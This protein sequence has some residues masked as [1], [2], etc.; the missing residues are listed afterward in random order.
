MK[1]HAG[2][3]GAHAQARREWMRAMALALL[4]SGAGACAAEP[5]VTITPQGQ[6]A[7]LRQVM[8]HFSEPMQH[9]PER[10]GDGPIVLRCE[11][12]PAR[13][14]HGN[15]HWIDERTAV[16]DLK[17]PLPPRS[18]CT[19]TL[20]ANLRTT[21]GAALPAVPDVPVN[22][23]GPTMQAI[24]PAPGDATL[25]VPRQSFAMLLNGDADLARF[26]AGVHCDVTAN[27][28]GA[29]EHLGVRPLAPAE[30]AMLAKAL[31]FERHLNRV[32]TFACAQPLPPGAQLRLSWM[33][34]RVGA[35]APMQ[36]HVDYGV[37]P[38]LSVSFEP[39]C[40]RIEERLQRPSGLECDVAARRVDADAAV[41]V[42][43]SHSIPQSQAMRVRL[44]SPRGDRVPEPVELYGGDVHLPERPIR[45]IRFE[46]PF[47]A[48]DRLEAVV[49]ADLVDR[50]GKTRIDGDRPLPPITVASRSGS[51]D[52]AVDFETGLFAVVGRDGP[53]TVHAGLAQGLSVTGVRTLR[54]PS[55]VRLV[56]GFDDTALMGWLE[57]S[58]R[59]QGA[60]F[61][62]RFEA[63]RELGSAA[64]VGRVPALLADPKGRTDGDLLYTSSL[65]LLNSDSASKPAQLD[66]TGPR[67]GIA[68]QE[69]GLQV[70][71]LA[72]E[73]PP[74]DIVTGTAYER[75]TVL[76]TDLAVHLLNGRDD[77]VVWVTA[78]STGKPVAQATVQLSDCAGHRLAAGLTDAQGLFRFWA[79]QAV[80]VCTFAGH[81]TSDRFASARAPAAAGLQDVAFVWSS[82]EGGLNPDAW[83]MP[84]A[85]GIAF[86]GS[87]GRD[88][89]AT[90]RTFMPRSLLLAGQTLSMKHWLRQHDD[91]GRALPPR[92]RWPQQVV[93]VDPSGERVALPLAWTDR[94]DTQWS[95]QVPAAARRGRWDVEMTWGDRSE[96]V[97]EF[98]VRDFRVPEAEVTLRPVLAPWRNSRPAT[99][100]VEARYFNGGP[101]VGLAVDLESTLK[102]ATPQSGPAHG[103]QAPEGF[104]ELDFDAGAFPRL[105][106]DEWQAQQNF[107]DE[108]YDD[109][110]D[111]DD[112]RSDPAAIPGRAQNAVVDAQ[113][114]ARF[115]VATRADPN[116]SQVDAVLRF[117]DPDGEVRRVRATGLAW[118]SARRIGLSLRRLQGDDEHA[119]LDVGV[120]D[121][122]GR[123]LAGATVALSLA[124]QQSRADQASLAN[125]IDVV[126]WHRAWKPVALPVTCALVTDGAGKASC[127]LDIARNAELALDASVVDET[128]AWART[129]GVVS[130]AYE[131]FQSGSRRDRASRPRHVQQPAHLDP[132][133]VRAPAGVHAVGEHLG[134]TIPG[135]YDKAPALLTVERDGILE[136]RVVTLDGDDP[137]VDWTVGRHWM[138]G[139][140][141]GVTVVQV[142]AGDQGQGRVGDQFAPVLRVGG[143]YVRVDTSPLVLKVDVQAA[144]TRVRPGEV[145][146]LHVKVQR[147]D[148]RPLPTNTRVA[149]AVVNESLFGM[150]SDTSDVL[151]KFLEA[152]TLKTVTL[153]S[154]QGMRHLELMNGVIV[155]SEDFGR[156]PDGN[157]A[158]SMQRIAGVPMPAADVVTVAGMRM[159]GDPDQSR[160][161]SAFDSA[162]AWLPDIPLAADGSADVDVP[163]NDSLAQWRVMAVADA[164]TDEDAL[165]AGNG[166]A[167]FD[168]SQPLQLSAGLP[169]VVRTGD[170][171][172]ATAT[173]RNDT[174]HPMRVRV[175]ARA[176]ARD[177]GAHELELGAHASA[178]VHWDAVAASTPGETVW[179]FAAG[180]LDGDDS[181]ADRV[182]FRQQVLARVPLRVEQGALLQLDHAFDWRLQPTGVGEARVAI[183]ATPSLAGELPGL[184]EW[185]KTY[186]YDCLE[187]RVSRAIG[188]RD[189]AAW[190][191][192]VEDLPAYFDADGLL[193]WFPVKDDL[194]R[195]ERDRRDTGGS[196]V[197]SSYVLSITEQARAQG[198]PFGLPAALRQ[199][200]LD[201]LA[202]VARGS[203]RREVGGLA[204]GTV[205]EQ[206]LRRVAAIEALSRAGAATPDMLA[207]IAPEPAWPTSAMVDLRQALA[208][209]PATPDRTASL[210]RIDAALRARLDVR[211]T[212]VTLLAESRGQSWQMRDADV[213]AIRLA[214]LAADDPAWQDLAPR[215]LAGALSR[216]RAGHWSTTV[217]NALGVLMDADFA[218]RHEAGPVRGVT[219]AQVSGE[220]TPSRIDWQSTPA[221]ATLDL[222]LP[223]A[224][225][226]T[227][228]LEHAGTGTPWVSV[229]ESAAV[230]VT[231]AVNHGFTVRRS[232]R[233]LVPHPGGVLLRGDILRVHLDVHAVGDATWVAVDDPIPA[234]AT[235]IDDD[236]TTPDWTGSRGAELAYVDKRFDH[237][238]AF[239]SRVAAGRFSVDYTIRLDTAGRFSLPA[240][241]VE[242]M[243]APDMFGE[244]PNAPVAV[245]LH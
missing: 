51:S 52:A 79:A 13:V 93:L 4:A 44:R 31:Q 65:S 71:E 207:G 214:T 194:G 63:N 53:T 233:P 187:Q 96:R 203:L 186:P 139:A 54:V 21:A 2:G 115:Q 78:R 196:D 125:G 97:D 170:Q 62:S 50:L 218:Q 188:R 160:L 86:A 103:I 89:A 104:R 11:G 49:P 157:L 15:A 80:V 87:A 118:P 42:T 166:V 199:R 169:P 120:T 9:A 108:L 152:A 39:E 150:M 163:T 158:D 92:S 153:A 122:A 177:M 90:V 206:V 236:D 28:G 241:R 127:R 33:P 189:A 20:Q 123:P 242:A 1:V 191:H 137:V 82:W 5:S 173:V 8:A 110:I 76:V 36:E 131:G 184:A 102:L 133:D 105:A 136:S 201:A 192:V 193:R 148:G 40:G 58:Q 138:P 161:R 220:A 19:V 99:L 129:H 12:A 83:K 205:R 6:V 226:P 47:Q 238:Q 128:G 114:H 64:R 211:G 202:A 10:G 22:T 216:Q 113:G 60:A 95:W 94:G 240:T 167:R 106:V 116:V 45:G 17:F 144:Q 223:R 217:A 69:P 117:D 181:A 32:A 73:A 74:G 227:L 179:E 132:L 176:A 245:G 174:A 142:Q 209:L 182:Q 210:Q 25:V 91:H 81:S 124:I 77:G 155:S 146:H 130:P 27:P 229:L 213:D 70:V 141:V 111:A 135:H 222:A 119:R 29:V 7:S 232:V 16:L 100:E 195:F 112:T 37:D 121:L 57:R 243:Y 149:L 168:T 84:G 234:G 244:S 165:L 30:R 23:G 228:H 231:R 198:L 183:S 230:D 200:V 48:G 164:S 126:H 24:I 67:G 185:F 154:Q 61:V 180:T 134:T 56:D 190:A 145:A 88:D 147:V 162:L 75:T 225:S 224:A 34:E 18:R 46:G 38:G 66:A 221:G 101:A 68:L 204:V 151:R 215:L 239:Y 14:G 143:D 208:R 197:L 72:Y 55:E 172:I 109:D 235:I 175:T 107:A 156:F 59:F 171:S 159:K 212:R 41:R 26:T 35:E 219:M 178:D 3:G 140:F 237:Y 85:I 98:E 43:F